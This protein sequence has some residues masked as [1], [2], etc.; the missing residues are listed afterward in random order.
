MRG[1]ENNGQNEGQD[2]EESSLIGE[3]SRPAAMEALPELCEFVASIE[4]QEGFSD[5]RISQVGS[6]LNAALENVVA[7]AYGRKSGEIRIACKRDHWGK[8]LIAISDDGEPV[9][10]LLADV[11]FAGEEAMGDEQMAEAARLI[12]RMID[13]IEYKRVERENILTFFASGDGRG[14]P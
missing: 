8:L 5:D 3:I 6:A 11:A 10:I 13:N 9:N 1:R 2:E 4:R 7:R 12:K 14:K